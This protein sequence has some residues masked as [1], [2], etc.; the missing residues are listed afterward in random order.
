MARSL[1][2]LPGSGVSSGTAATM[3]AVLALATQVGD[4]VESL[5]KREA[6]VKDS[7][8]LLPGHGGFLD[9]L[10]ALFWAFPVSWLMFVL[11]GALP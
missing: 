2:N 8:R 1:G 10:D 3:G 11:V 6:G 7:G 9:R 5:L 4:L